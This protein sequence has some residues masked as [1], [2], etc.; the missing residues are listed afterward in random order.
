MMDR[1]QTAM[2]EEIALYLAITS[3]HRFAAS[4]VIQSCRLGSLPI[5]CTSVQPNYHMTQNA[6]PCRIFSDAYLLLEHRCD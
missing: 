5:I 4:S 6:N 2:V 3:L 1:I